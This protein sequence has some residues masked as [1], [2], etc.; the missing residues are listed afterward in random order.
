MIPVPEETELAR[1]L[2]R[3]FQSRTTW[4]SGNGSRSPEVWNAIAEKATENRWRCFRCGETFTTP[5]SA[6][7]H[8]GSHPGAKPGCLLEVELGDERGWE[9][10][11]RKLEAEIEIWKKRALK[12]EEECET[13]EGRIS[14]WERTTG[15][16]STHDFRMRLDSIEGR[17]ITETARLDAALEGKEFLV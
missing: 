4:K 10:Y 3:E 17:L 14:D 11:F 7:D 16:R 5:G 2:R 8:F 1:Q 12:A 9:M 6:E 15:C 13:L